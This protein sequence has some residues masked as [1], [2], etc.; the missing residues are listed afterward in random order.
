MTIKFVKRT[1]LRVSRRGLAVAAS[2]LVALLSVSTIFGNAEPLHA[3][4]IVVINGR[5]FGHGVGLAQDGAYW[6]GRAGRS[7]TEILRLFFPG[8][9]V[10]KRGGTVRV[11]LGGG[12][13]AQLNFPNGGTI[14]D[15]RIPAG[16][17]VTVRAAGNDVIAS[18][19]R[20][21][22]SN[23]GSADSNASSTPEA[24]TQPPSLADS[25]IAPAPSPVPAP[26]AAKS[27]TGSADVSVPLAD[28]SV[29]PSA[30]G[31]AAKTLNPT[32]QSEP[33]PGVA[34]TNPQ[35]LRFSAIYSARYAEPSTRESPLA[36]GENETVNA[37]ERFQTD[38]PIVSSVIT[39]PA[40][41]ATLAGT[42]TS[43]PASSPT[44]T[45]PTSD[46]TPINAG[47]AN[48]GSANPVP[49]AVIGAA[50]PVPE[51]GVPT[52]PIVTSVASIAGVST[53]LEPTGQATAP[54]AVEST[55][56]DNSE[57]STKPRS[58]T[59]QRSSLS[60]SSGGATVAFNGRR[61]RGS[62]DFDA[63][64]GS[65]RITNSVDLEDYLKGMGEILTPSWPSAALQSQAIAAR[66]YALRTMAIDGQVCPTQRCQVYLGAQ[67]EYGKMN[68]AVDATR[69][70][71][72]TY[73]GKLAATFYSASGG[74]T[75]A[76]PEEGFGG[77][78]SQQPYLKAGSYP[79]G[80]VL[81][82]TVRMP[83]GE[84]ARRVG[85]G[86]SPSGVTVTRVGP[87]GRALE[88]TVDGSSGPLRVKGPKFDAALGLK[89]T[90]FTI[91]EPVFGSSG[92]G[93]GGSN[94]GL[95][96][97]G[98][99][100]DLASALAALGL[101]NAAP[102]AGS[103]EQ[104][105]LVSAADPDF[106][107]GA[108]STLPPTNLV[109]SA[110][111]GQNLP[112]FGGSS[113]YGTSDVPPVHNNLLGSD[114]DTPTTTASAPKP[115]QPDNSAGSTI[116]AINLPSGD[117]P[118][119]SGTGDVVFLAVPTALL[120]VVG[121][122]LRRRMKSNRST[123]SAAP[124]RQP[125]R[126]PRGERP[127]DRSRPANRSSERRANRSVPNNN[128]NNNNDSQRRPRTSP[129]PTTPP[130]GSRVTETPFTDSTTLA[131]SPFTDSPSTDSPP[132]DSPRPGSPR[133]ERAE[134]PQPLR[135][136]QHRDD[137]R[138]SA[139]QRQLLGESNRPPRPRTPPVAPRSGPQPP[140]SQQSGPQRV[141]GQ[142][143]GLQRAGG[144]PKPGSLGRRLTEQ[145]VTPPDQP[146]AL[147]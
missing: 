31:T 68:A 145:A 44:P 64:G 10:A 137:N 40:T 89:S 26:A 63:G 42:A 90:F 125:R 143:L 98:S 142:E 102:G 106:L 116:E 19:L 139:A 88:V 9:V 70:K 134:V 28:S 49:T 128:N 118:A 114:P 80:D 86:G 29:T 144:S 47:P 141:G 93:I 11:P 21:A 46:T 87:S 77:G 32:S 61:Y 35:V 66:T 38:T 3:Q 23:S 122:G 33:Q 4:S 62:I 56:S 22:S 71:V 126:K 51:G 120:G 147:K 146:A 104:S 53:S 121:F 127:T 67:A 123:A 20:A 132:P 60:A 91:N 48:P 41:S 97:A 136:T 39:V 24:A 14:G 107:A 5:G 6:M 76:T 15:L 75:I 74:G 8:T 103:D 50:N 69:G 79:T 111:D 85:Y 101:S 82:W 16:G 17:L 2:A 117:D 13:S 12:G 99:E 129:R 84:V 1:P 96:S 112:D 43:A 45:S 65:L 27:E 138:A 105:R 110:S 109:P 54:T 59:T 73:G 7:A 95:G 37:V 83:L 131:N 133:R 130:K 25:S 55:N 135:S 92:S 94:S 119:P 58:G 57:A 30:V 108:A 78:S 34:P 52:A 140:G 36:N 124:A 113:G 81:A 18:E 100:S 115:T 72:L